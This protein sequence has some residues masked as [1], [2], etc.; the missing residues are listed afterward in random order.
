MHAVVVARRPRSDAICRHQATARSKASPCRREPP[1]AQKRERRLVGV[2][3]AGARAAFDRHV[4]DRHPLVD[5]HRVERA[6]AVLVGE[7]DAALD[8]EAADDRQ[9]DV[10]R[11]DA[12]RQPAVDVDA[13]DLQRI[14]RQALRREHVAHL[15][16]ADAERDGAERAVRR[17]VA[18]AA[19]DRHARLRETELRADHVDDALV[20][21]CRAPT[22]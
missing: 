7:A 13:P 17:R 5:R 22:G 16:G 21:G 10:L 18:V 14:E 12:R 6:A 19:R 9:D 15:R 3:V 2:D 4:A 11:V 20:R 1:S 8:A